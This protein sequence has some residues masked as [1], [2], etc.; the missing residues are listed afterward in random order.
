MLQARK[1][2]QAQLSEEIKKSSE[3]L[4][5]D[6]ECLSK[7]EQAC[8]NGVVSTEDFKN[9]M[10]GAS[11]SAKEYA[12]ETKGASG[13]T[14]VFKDKQK[15]AQVELEN[16]KNKIDGTS[17]AMKALSIA[18]NMLIMWGIS[19]AIQFTTEKLDQLAHSS[20][21]CK[22]RVEDLMSSYNSAMT[23]ADNN[24]KKSEELA[25]DYEELA[26]GVNELGENISLT[27]E[28]YNKY[29]SIV[30]EIAQMF[31]NLVK[32]YTNQ[33]NAIL[34]LKGNVDGLRDAYKNAQKE[35]YN[36]LITSGKNNN[37]N[38]IID[39]WNNNKKAGKFSKLFNLGLDDI[40]KGISMT[41]AVKQLKE[42]QNMTAEEYRKLKSTDSRKEILKLTDVQKDILY[43][44]YLTKSL[45]LNENI[46]DKDFEN[47]KKQAKALVQTYNAEIESSLSNVRSLANAYLMT[48]S[49]YEKLD[50]SAKNA[51]SM[52]IN[53][54]DK[55]IANGFEKKSD[56]GA[57]VANII[58]T[59]SDNKELKD[60]LV[61]MFELDTDEASDV[62]KQN[63][64]KYS[65]DISKALGENNKS[66]NIRLGFD[67]IKILPQEEKISE[68]TKL[69]ADEISNEF[70]KMKDWGLE[71][72]LSDAKDGTLQT[73]FGNVDMD[74][75]HIITW[76]EELKNTY[77]KEL[78]SWKY[79]PENGSVDTVFG[80]S[81]RFGENL[82]GKGWEVAFTP[83]LPNGQLLDKVT[84]YKYINSIIKDAYKTDKNITETELKE[85]DAKGKKI[86]DIF[87]NGIF[88]GIDSSQD[89][90]N[91]AEK[92]GKLM[93]FSGKFGS[94][95]I[96]KQNFL[97]IDTNTEK[98]WDEII[99]KADEYK[100]TIENTNK[101][102][103]TI[104]QLLNVGDLSKVK[105]QLFDLARAGKLDKDT[106]ESTKEFSS[107]LKLAG[108]EADDALDKIKQLAEE[109]DDLGKMD[110]YVEGLDKL[111]SAYKL[112]KE[113]DVIDSSTLSSIQNIFGSGTKEFQKFKNVVM[114]GSGDLQGAFNQLANAY[115]DTTG[116]LD[117]LTEANKKH[118]I[119]ELKS[120]GVVNAQAVVE[121]RLASI[122]SQRQAVINGLNACNAHLNKT[123]ANLV[124]TTNNLEKATWQEI[125]ALIEE[126]GQSKNTA[127]ALALYALNKALSNAEQI[128]EEGSIA[129]IKSLAETAGI[130]SNIVAMYINAKNGNIKDSASA[131]K[132]YEEY[133]KQL[134][135]VEAKYN[136]ASQQVAPK[137]TSYAPDV[138]SEK[139]DIGDKGGGNKG[140]IKELS[141]FKQTIDWCEQSINKLNNAISLF[142]NKLNNAK[143][144][145]KRISLL[146]TLINKQQELTSAYEKTYNVYDKKYNTALSKLSK[147]D[148]KKVESGVYKLEQ[149]K[150]RA[151]SGETSGAEK[152]YNNIKE[153]L[154]WRDNFAKANEEVVSSISQM[155]EYAEQLISIPWEKA[156]EKV[157]RLNNSIDL[158]NTKLSNTNGYVKKNKILTKQL[159]LQKQIVS[160]YKNAIKTEKSW[161]ASYK[162][163]LDKIYSG[164]EKSV[165]SK[166]NKTYKQKSDFNANG[167][168]KIDKKASKKQKQLIKEY[169]DSVLKLNAINKSKKISTDG[170][171]GSTLKIAQKYNAILEDIRENTVNLK[172]EQAELEA[173]KN[174]T[175]MSQFENIQS[176]YDRYTTIRE[177]QIEE[178]N[179][180]MDLAESNGRN[181][182]TSYYIELMRLENE[183]MKKL[184]EERNNLKKRADKATAYTD[185]W[186]EMQSDIYD[187]ESEIQQAK[188]SIQDYQNE[189]DELDWS[190]FERLQAILS[191]LV[192]ESDF[193]DNI[194][195]SKRLTDD[196]GLTNE[197]L[198]TLGL[199]ASNYDVYMAKADEYANKVDELNKK[200]ATD[201]YNQ[202][203]IKQR[204]EYLK[205]QQDSIKSALDEKKSIIEL[206]TDGLQAEQDA[207]EELIDK[208]KEALDA[209]EDLYSFRKKV[210]E[211]TKA[212]ADLEKQINALEGDDSDENR[213]KLQTLKA[214]LADARSDLEDT[215]HSKS[216]EDTKNGL[217]E[218]LKN[219]KSQLDEYLEDSDKVFIDSLTKVN[220]N[221]QVISDTIKSTAKEVGYTISNEM[222]GAWNTAGKA[223]TEYSSTFANTSASII[224][225][226]NGIKSA[227]EQTVKAYEN[228][229]NI[230]V[231]GSQNK[232]SQYTSKS[233]NTDDIADFI[234]EN[235]KKAS[236][237][238]S[239]YLDTNRY[240]YEKTGGYVLT[241][242]GELQLAEML[243]MNTKG[244]TASNIS[245][246][247]RNRILDKLKNSGFSTGGFIN[248][249]M[250]KQTGEDGFVLARH[251]EAI[252]TQ[253]QAKQFD[254]LTNNLDMLNR[255][256]DLPIL[257]SVVSRNNLL[258][259]Y[260]INTS[261]KVDG[262]ATNEIVNGIGNIVST[263]VEKSITK[264]NQKNYTN[265][266]RRKMR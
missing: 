48:N 239:Y 204:D 76:S 97:S 183:N 32:G 81:N 72:Y 252:L 63:I 176:D 1:N 133:Q 246:E 7:Y 104:E 196:N 6:V 264:I 222:A 83:I 123:N 153:A 35:A 175:I 261:V 141:E 73:V 157:D 143:S 30:N 192:D 230:S 50:D 59:F 107:L 70:Q 102:R 184:I 159:V 9:I 2:A 172:K 256:V 198:A 224:A 191:N 216:V 221:T 124:I 37:G 64:L 181:L 174:E 94:F 114:S 151:K 27:S 241:K 165:L 212:I 125:S 209:E 8:K 173:Q 203:Y 135:S 22:E 150:G 158:L 242:K 33:G 69:F 262:V 34:T 244:I 77:K 260:E 93:N 188:K 228:Y 89:K 53:S 90:N 202:T 3:Q 155:E 21:Y 112:F 154:E 238:K 186:V 117:G 160:Q 49:D 109:T 41:D 231:T 254:Y 255:L 12:V 169:N 146:K 199:H 187:C 106:L 113:K 118:Y 74:K 257:D 217:D 26:K 79:N 17:I 103:P 19:K 47:A 86:G 131:N 42:I 266:I 167:T 227:W 95:G 265:G 147:S 110:K 129:Q 119:E 127:Q 152:R 43:G 39:Q 180:K 128:H 45:G 38:D 55:N 87:V 88:A 24:A 142:E 162:K 15:Q 140:G 29:N 145:T 78:A 46:S 120:N 218:M 245:V 23:T 206:T 51:V 251:G 189:I 211:Q 44:S 71:D 258:P 144:F 84:V 210:N 164:S 5:V 243:G 171:S 249:S 91:M 126:S 233:S 170:L 177:K 115:L 122:Q 213:K 185:A 111:S 161:L 139:K 237:P 60:K 82:N 10:N 100:T 40:G 226:I 136:N 194:L 13:S 18:G 65:K 163:S 130:A 58:S 156:E 116:A 234:N 205:A 75:R 134:N 36:L 235:K 31:P 96:S 195:S 54:L 28:E 248:A 200:L 215:M 92:I 179:N 62:A 263:E 68:Q 223:V 214:D 57:Y 225:S 121:S 138:D 101:S 166:I 67:D 105:D 80:M 201:K 250:L 253:K 132:I 208:K 137:I 85:L 178:I 247:F 25:K 4:T 61:A 190:N 182:G 193:L 56:V 232:Q 207:L 11:V 14:E 108:V 220:G 259:T 197:G 98:Q 66:F 16:T 99:K 52:L 149:F 219:S 168:L 229:A 236:H 20:E 240:I 148:R